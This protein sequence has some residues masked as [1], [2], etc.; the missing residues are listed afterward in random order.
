M[1]LMAEKRDNRKDARDEKK[2]DV[3]DEQKNAKD[4]RKKK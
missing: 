4:Q 3:R 1:V 2:Q